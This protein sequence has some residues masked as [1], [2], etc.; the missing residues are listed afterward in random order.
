[1]PISRSASEWDLAAWA[2]WLSADSPPDSDEQPTAARDRNA[3]VTAHDL[4]FDRKLLGDVLETT[5]FRGEGEAFEA[6]HR[7]VAEF[8]GAQ[9]L[10]RPSSVA[11][12]A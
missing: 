1:V 10:A 8:V 12:V 5:L 3:Y 11:A 4:R 2:P 7:A 6:M 9:P